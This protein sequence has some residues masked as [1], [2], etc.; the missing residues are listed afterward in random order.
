[1]KGR[2]LF[3]EDPE[4]PRDIPTVCKEPSMTRQSEAESCDIN[5]LMK[6]YEKTGVLPMDMR[7]AVF[8]D[9]SSFGSFRE[10]METVRKATDAFMELPAATR[11]QFGNDPVTF[12]DFCGDP[13]NLPELERLGL[14]ET[15][16]APVSS[17]VAPEAPQAQS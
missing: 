12:I 2:L 1:M 11:A 14:V 13:A 7:E 16:Q 8:A 9:V 4:G 17:E 6:R 15:A 10:V 5:V 3:P